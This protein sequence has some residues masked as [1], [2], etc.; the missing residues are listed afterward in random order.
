MGGKQGSSGQPYVRH[1]ETAVRGV[2][3]GKVREVVFKF[4]VQRE[5]F[6]LTFW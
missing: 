4:A 1:E 5:K 3:E 2:T 6:A